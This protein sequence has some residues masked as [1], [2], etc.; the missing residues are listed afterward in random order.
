MSVGSLMSGFIGSLQL[1]RLIEI[2]LVMFITAAV[3]Y[4]LRVES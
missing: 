1:K 2:P 4:A 3:F